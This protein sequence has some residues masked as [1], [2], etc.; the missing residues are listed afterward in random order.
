MLAA[1][2]AHTCVRR[3]PITTRGMA[4][5]LSSLRRRLHRYLEGRKA[6]A[7]AVAVLGL[8][9]TPVNNNTIAGP[10]GFMGLSAEENGSHP[11]IITHDLFGDVAWTWID[12]QRASDC[13]R[14]MAPLTAYGAHI[15][16]ARGVIL[17]Q[18]TEGVPS[19]VAR[20]KLIMSL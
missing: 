4:T 18:T 12:G 11:A 1:G 14:S 7:P 8:S 16:G 5:A 20:L 17:T 3:R 10:A 13:G 2:T 6:G 15:W 19:P 9:P